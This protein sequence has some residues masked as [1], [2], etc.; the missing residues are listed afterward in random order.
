MSRMVRAVAFKEGGFYVAQALEVD[1]AA[2]GYTPDDAFRRLR[3]LL[4]AEAE[5]A[6]R[7]ERD[8][9]EIGSAPRPFYHLYENGAIARALLAA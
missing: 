4:R 5:D 2:Q 9:F 6:I 8:V 1:L 7:H 3:V